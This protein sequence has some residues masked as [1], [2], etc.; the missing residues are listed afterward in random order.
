MTVMRGTCGVLGIAPGLLG[1]A[2]HLVGDALIGQ[3]LITDCL[4]HLFLCLADTLI[5]FSCYL[6]LIHIYLQDLFIG[7]A[8]HALVLPRTSNIRALNGGSAGAHEAQ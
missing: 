8:R 6:V 3:L 7:C 1:R 2:L 4:A 5:E